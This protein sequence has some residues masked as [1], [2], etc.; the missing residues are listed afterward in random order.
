[1]DSNQDPDPNRSGAD[2][3]LYLLQHNAFSSSFI[4]DSLWASLGTSIGF[5][6]LIALLFC[7]LRPFNSVV[8]APKLKHADDKH[9][10]PPLG[11]GIFAWFGPVLGTKEQ[12]LITQIGLDA[13]IFL[14]FTRMC[15]NIFCII[16]IVGCGVLL[17]INMIKGDKS[18]TEHMSRI[19]EFTPVAT[20]GSANWGQVICAWIFTI[21]VAGFLWWNYR[22]VLQLRRQYFNSP[23]YQTS[24]HARTLMINDLPKDYRNDEGIGRVIDQVVPES[25]FCRTAIARN[26]KAVPKL[27][28]E[29]EKMV[30]DLEKHL[31]KYL[32][33]PDNLPRARP[34][35]K[36]SRQDPSYKSY[37]R[38]QKVDAIEYLTG[39]IRELEMEIKEVR[40]S[41]DKRNALPYGF[42]S[43]EEI[44][45]AHSIAFAARKKHPRGTTI[46]LAPRPHDVIW[47]N[48]P[49]SKSD[50]RWRRF[51]N[52][53]WITLLTFLWIPPNAMISIFLVNLSNLGL[54]WPAFQRS[55]TANKTLWSIIQGVASPALTSLIYLL[56]PIVFRR[57]SIR[58]GDRSKTA[59]ER[60][61]TAKL[62]AFFTFNN[63]IVFSIFS[64]LWKFVATVINDT[65]KGQ[66][67]WDAILK[68][69]F[70]QNFLIALC[71]LSPF[72]VSWLLQRNL[73]AAIDL[74]QLWTLVWSFCARKFSSP[75]PRELI[76][77]TAPQ[78]FD[79]ASYYNYFLFYATVTL[80]FATLQ[81]L[82]LPA[83]AFYYMIDVY[84]KKYLLLY[85]FVTKTE[86]GGMF[87]RTIFN[88]MV[89]A[90]ILANL[91]VFL[92]V[93]VQ[94]E[95]S[96]IEAYAV[97]PL[98]FLMLAFKI[99][100]ARAYDDKIHYFATRNLLKDP[101]A[102]NDPYAKGKGDRLASRYG[103]P[104][105]YRPLITPMV[106][107]RA[108]NILASIYRG[109]LTNGHD[110]ADLDMASV[111]GYSDTYAMNS[112]KAGQPGKKDVVPGFE[113]V[114]ENHLDFSY[115][116]NRAEF[117]EDHGAGEIYSQ[118]ER[119]GTSSTFRTG[120]GS[121][122][123]SRAGSPAPPMPGMRR[124]MTGSSLA[125]G[126][127]L[128]VQS[129]PYET[130]HDEAAVPLVRGAARMPSSTPN[131]HPADAENEMEVRPPGF[132]GG[133]PQGYGGLPQHE[134]EADP[135]SYDYFRT[136]RQNGG[137]NGWTG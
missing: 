70:G 60:H 32:K 79:Y 34:E 69:N 80:C 41:I 128:G 12:D 102:A 125:H 26:V 68:A 88:R 67:A 91:V 133:G 57:M 35:C 13:I 90:T 62:Y 83:A 54:V 3:L 106:H 76:E 98:P 47:N 114:P 5:S 43:Y 89:F 104:A 74:A 126:G 82:V 33:T 96:H 22:K 77:L 16:A 127:D 36:P 75:T 64:T 10:P 2:E 137:F 45:E 115:Y 110:G 27:I 14:R 97:V 9:A 121:P 53:L 44:S 18:A 131:V 94:G 85:I 50:R 134:E 4:Q 20:Y 123:T 56:L 42:A 49:L 107:A 6:A 28:A 48:M 73:G 135:T 46:V 39:R 116:K 136:R 8:Y 92:S 23:E 17:P 58:A 59:R 99:Y 25:S 129:S 1:M 100:C 109:R 65:Q 63:L 19:V 112:M 21:T 86:S 93:W 122:E 132:L 15:R 101:E 38:G 105:L 40:L 124:V 78:A 117:G 84:L 72:W 118:I 66:N 55:L 30:R 29:H 119:P 71:Q 108:Q 37:P 95:N 113:V 7:C 11:N 31:A 87:W 111:S 52:N 130:R 81:P 120:H 103:H 24:L 51:V 61:V